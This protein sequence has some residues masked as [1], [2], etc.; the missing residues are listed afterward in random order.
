[1]SASGYHGADSGGGAPAFARRR[2]RVGGLVQGVGFRPFVYRLALELDLS[3]WVENTPAG[4][5]IEVEG[6]RG[7]VDEFERRLLAD[8]P[9][10]ARI[11]SLRGRP[12][13]LRGDRGFQIRASRESGTRRA[14]V[15]PDLATCP[16]CLAEIQ[17]PS[18]RRYRYPFT[19]CTHCGP[20]FSILEQ[21]PY[22]RANTG[23]RRFTMCRACQAEYEDPNNRRFHAQPNACPEC[24]PQLQLLDAAGREQGRGEA[25]LDAAVDALDDGRIV[26]VKGVGGF[27]LMVDAAQEV[28]VAELRRRKRRP[29]KPLAVMYPDLETTA[30]ACRLSAAERA[31]LVSPQAPIVLLRRSG[32]ALAPA[33][34]PGNP[35]LG[36]ML[37][38]N[39]LHALIC[40][41]L[42][43]PVVA[44]SGNRSDE[45]VCIDEREALDRL[46]RVADLFL[47]HD[48]PIERPVEDS[49]AQVV[50]ER[51]MLL[52]VGR[53]Y[54]PLRLPV[55]APEVVLG[56]GGHMRASIAVVGPTGT[57]LGAHIGD[58]QSSDA[59]RRWREDVDSL[60]SLYR[61]EPARVAVDQHPDYPSVS[62]AAEIGLPLETVQHHHA[63]AAAAMA[64]LELDG[65]VLAVCWDGTGY[66]GDGTIWGGEFLQ[67]TTASFRRVAHLH[68]FSLPGGERALREP[69]RG[70][71]GA[72]FAVAPQLAR[73]NDMGL[74]PGERG[75]VFTMLERGVNAPMTSSAG[76]L[77]DAVAAL[78]GLVRQSSFDGQAATALQSAAEEA[79][80]E[81][82]ALPFEINQHGGCWVLDWRPGLK[83]LLA[84]RRSGVSV[85]RLAMRFH[86]MLALG[87][88][89]ICSQFGVERVVLTGGCFQNA[90]LLKRCRWALAAVRIQP[91][92]PERV[93]VNDGGLSLGQA[94]VGAARLRAATRGEDSQ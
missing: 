46:G 32:D 22:D 39:P 74:I 69:T 49:V 76:R 93:P 33:V 86:N 63:H 36:V 55:T 12:R 25:A 9:V 37:P 84:G 91:L 26:A 87:L 66:G 13:P 58:L 94:V 10:N 7:L 59:R 1:M 79:E 14:G 75:I 15:L 31:L 65:P 8:A 88:A 11:D 30:A 90:L 6:P 16:D 3:G 4:V 29:H 23:M 28:A 83:A 64:E 5:V 53:G 45:P 21:L 50:D 35:R 51:P 18:D 68:P 2:L 82:S 17:D 42:G 19:N 57:V 48:R 92:R 44:T 54:A 81:G 47:M 52:R 27:H 70:A 85:P 38:S 34:A 61:L 62:L 80:S 73:D 43:R 67:C 72:L 89:E 41:D 56:A 20:R 77:F 60:Q 40:A 71:L 78:L 24:G